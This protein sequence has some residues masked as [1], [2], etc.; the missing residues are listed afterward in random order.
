M[1]NTSYLSYCNFKCNPHRAPDIKH[2]TTKFHYFYN[3][4]ISLLVLILFYSFPVWTFPAKSHHNSLQILI[5]SLLRK[6]WKDHMYLFNITRRNGLG[7][8]ILKEIIEFHSENL[9]ERVR[10]INNLTVV[11]I[12]DYDQIF[13]K[14]PSWIKAPP[15][16]WVHIVKDC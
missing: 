8:L 2:I 11:D 6:I 15:W 9:Y 10:N 13:A 4:P 3:N 14:R 5:N 7:F 1:E 16:Q 12:T